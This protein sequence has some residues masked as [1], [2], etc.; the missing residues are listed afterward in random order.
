MKTKVLAIAMITLSFVV[1]A[2]I[3]H[4]ST[5]GNVGIGTTTPTEG[6]VVIKHQAS[7]GLS[8]N[9][10]GA[11]TILG[12]NTELAIGASNLKNGGS[13]IQTR[14]R[15]TTY[16]SYAYPLVLNPLGGYVGIGTNTPKESLHIDGNVLINAF[17]K[18]NENGLFFRKDFNQTNKYNLSILTYDH[19]NSGASADGLSINAYDGISFS[20]GSNTRNE[21]MKI[22]TNGNVG[23]GVTI[24]KSK[25]DILTPATAYESFFRVKT[26]DAPGDEL[27]IN[28]A[29]ET[30]GQFIP[31]I[32][33]KHTSDNRSALYLTGS[34]DES[35]DAGN[36]P[37]MTFD[38]RIV[39]KNVTTRPLFGWDSYGQRKMTLSAKGKLGI[40]TAIPREAKVVIKDQSSPSLS[41]N[42][43]GALAILGRNTELAIGASD[44]I[45]GGSWIQTRH[46]SA[47][48]SS[49]A[50]PLALNP[51]GGNVGIGTADT[52]GFKLGVN[53]KIAATEVKV[54]TYNN[55]PDF[56]FKKEYKLPTLT[57][58]EN[59]IKEK[60]HLENIPSAKEVKKDGFF[61]G[62][63]DAKLLQKIEELTLYTIDQEKKLNTQN[64]KI[65]KLEKEN[66]LLKSLL[67][68]VSKLE[69][70]VNN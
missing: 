10:T 15:S 11:L 3:I 56:V 13:W 45:N 16:D 24:P 53:G 43:T 6:K 31:N 50:Y 27:L 55:W 29:T 59:H 34:I 67:E 47:T 17:S 22:H 19:S 4:E 36:K 68:R 65:E 30:N 46:T 44:L 25:L 62:R 66:I 40:G 7:P 20:T 21:R 70:Q 49:H 37:I 52:K 38:S 12:Y 57:D 23:I 69:K 2:Q 51:L 5:N 18:G 1:N 33:G 9:K 54:A 61:L 26:S 63:M 41:G 39:S 42:K 35:N 48:Y 8:D 64:T 60:G 28:N 32:V 14:H 58:V